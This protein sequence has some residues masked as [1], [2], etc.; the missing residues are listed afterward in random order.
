MPGLPSFKDFIQGLKDDAKGTI[1]YVA[2]IAIVVLFGILRSSDK[3][4]TA[5]LEKQIADCDTNSRA[6]AFTSKSEND[7]LRGQI[8]ELMGNFKELKGEI[9]TLKKL[10]IIKE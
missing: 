7:Q 2:F 5:K 3:D 8:V 6:N 9:N 4:K 1:M 10:G